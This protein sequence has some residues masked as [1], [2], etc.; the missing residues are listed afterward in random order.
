MKVALG[1]TVKRKPMTI[2]KSA[3]E[4]MG[5][6][7]ME[8]RV[9][10]IHPRGRFHVVAFPPPARGVPSGGLTAGVKRAERSWLRESFFGVEREQ[11]PC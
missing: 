2:P 10:Y 9:V 1:D 7:T 11:S 8:G 3:S 4:V 5:Q 6:E